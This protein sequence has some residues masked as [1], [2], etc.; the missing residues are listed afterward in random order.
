MRADAALGIALHSGGFE[1]GRNGWSIPLLRVLLAPLQLM[2]AAPTALYLLTLTAFLFRPPAFA[3]HSI[4]RIT[5]VT[6]AL[7]VGVRQ[8]IARRRLPPSSL[9]VPLL[10]LAV[11]SS[12][13]MFRHSFEASTWS[14][15][16]AKFFVP[17]AMFWMA[18]LV[19]QEERSLWWLEK[20]C[21]VVLAY[22]SFISIAHLMGAYELVFPRFILDE[23][24]G[25]HAERARGPFL[26]AVANGV[27][28]N[29]LGLLAID[30]YRNEA[31]EGDG[32]N[33]AGRGFASG[34]SRD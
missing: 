3:F 34:H 28:I 14:V 20:F 33:R 7:V 1:R 13:G 29:M 11:L 18:G 27:T 23:N 15:L 26:Q 30:G 24:L 2:L 9:T 21:F 31:T 32:R 22:L 6:L 12:I 25:I 19:F 5:F 8:V 10:A 16:A 4:D 17:F